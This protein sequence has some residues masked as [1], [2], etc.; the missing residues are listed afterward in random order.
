MTSR[1]TP[2]RRSAFTLIE[3]LVVIAI[4]AILAGILFPAI[5][6]G[7]RTAKNN[8]AAAE[9]KNISGAIVMFFKDNG[10]LPVAA[11]EQGVDASAEQSQEIT[12]AKSKEIIKVLM[13][14]DTDLNPKGTVYLNSERPVVEGTYLDPWNRQY[15]IKLDLDYNGKI[16]FYSS[17]DFY[18]QTAIVFSLGADGKL[19]SSKNDNIAN[20]AL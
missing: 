12:E 1:F 2:S 15:R 13:G 5:N 19:V 17:P 8:K 16:E 10:Y 6:K 11:S 4:I 3:M 7:L 18:N 20:V 14:D 9:A